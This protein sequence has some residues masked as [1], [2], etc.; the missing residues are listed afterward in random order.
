[1]VYQVPKEERRASHQGYRIMINAITLWLE[2]LIA[3]F[4]EMSFNSWMI[5]LGFFIIESIFLGV[6]ILAI[7]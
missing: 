6:F 3:P 2:D 4:A 7:L 5:V 1:M